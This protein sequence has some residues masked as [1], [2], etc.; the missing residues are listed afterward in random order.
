MIPYREPDHL[1]KPGSL[2]QITI[3]LSLTLA[4]RVRLLV[5]ILRLIVQ[6]SE[7]QRLII[8]ELGLDVG[9]LEEVTMDQLSPWF[10]DPTCPTNAKKRP[11]LNEL[12]RVAKAEESFIKG[13]IGI[14]YLS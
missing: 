5:H 11:I 1:Q 9:K 7:E 4:E 3:E 8:L 2:Y 10:N 12:F 13:E 6:P 14:I